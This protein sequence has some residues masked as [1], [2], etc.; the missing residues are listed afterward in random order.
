LRQSGQQRP[1]IRQGLW[2]PPKWRRAGP[3]DP[4][5]CRQFQN[6]QAGPQQS[7]QIGSRLHVGRGLRLAAGKDL[8]PELRPPLQPVSQAL[9][10]VAV[11]QVL[12]QPGGLGLR[13]LVRQIRQQ[14]A[15]AQQG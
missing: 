4:L 10:R 2:H 9:G 6:G 3:V 8:P 13:R 5:P 12:P 11:G 14:Q 15:G 1:H 7:G